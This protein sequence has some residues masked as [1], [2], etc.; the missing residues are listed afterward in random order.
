MF[1][2][3]EIVEE[4]PNLENPSAYRIILKVK[5][6]ERFYAYASTA[7]KEDMYEVISLLLDR[8]DA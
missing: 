8:E 5:G 6:K 1:K 3:L 2:Y 7:P 4:G